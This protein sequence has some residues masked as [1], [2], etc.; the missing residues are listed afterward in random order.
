MLGTQSTSG[1][2]PW[3]SAHRSSD[4]PLVLNISTGHI[5]PQYHVVFDDS[6]STVN[7]HAKEE[8]PPSFW[9]RMSLDSHLYDSHV[10][11]IPLDSNYSIQLH[12]KWLTPPELEERRRSIEHQAKIRGT[13]N[14]PPLPSSKKSVIMQISQDC[15]MHVDNVS[16]PSPNVFDAVEYPSQLPDSKNSSQSNHEEPRRSRRINKGVFNSERF[17]DQV[18][19]SSLQDSSHYIPNLN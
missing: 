9:N 1:Y 11:R 3:T 14:M 7:Y 19:L 10:H 4:V 15:S 17:I 8:D 5:Y 13:F 2:L 16:D 12:D 18:F 6:F